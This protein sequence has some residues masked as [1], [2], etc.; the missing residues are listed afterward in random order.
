MHL[1]YPGPD[2]R[3]VGV[4]YR[5]RCKYIR[6][7]I[8]SSRGNTIDISQ[9]NNVDLALSLLDET[10]T[11]KSM[12]SFRKTKEMLSQALKGSVDRQ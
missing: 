10:S 8:L 3:R 5:P 12:S 11:G 4:C 2:Q 6:L 7:R 9:F 1:S